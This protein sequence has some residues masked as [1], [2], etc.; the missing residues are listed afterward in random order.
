[1]PAKPKAVK[2]PRT[3][4]A[5]PKVQRDGVVAQETLGQQW[6]TITPNG[7]IHVQS[8]KKKGDETESKAS[9]CAGAPYFAELSETGNDVRYI[10]S[11]IVLFH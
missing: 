4:A 6:W 1:M 2:K 11:H 10:H 9:A 3:K 8:I 5:A 7:L